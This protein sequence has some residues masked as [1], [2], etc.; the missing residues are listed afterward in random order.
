MEIEAADREGEGG[1]KPTSSVGR[2][3]PNK[4]HRSPFPLSFSLTP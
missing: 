4:L 3:L 1:K 2:S